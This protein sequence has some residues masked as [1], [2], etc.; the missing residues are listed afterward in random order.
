MFEKQLNKSTTTSDV[1]HPNIKI[2]GSTSIFDTNQ[3]TD[4]NYIRELFKFDT[5]PQH[6]HVEEA[7]FIYTI[8][9]TVGFSTILL[10]NNGKSNYICN[11]NHNSI[12]KTFYIA[13]HISWWGIP[14][15]YF[16]AF[17][18][19]NINVLNVFQ[20]MGNIKHCHQQTL[21]GIKE[22]YIKYNP[23]F[24][25]KE[26]DKICDIVIKDSAKEPLKKYKNLKKHFIDEY[27]KLTSTEVKD[28]CRDLIERFNRIYHPKIPHGHNVWMCT[29]KSNRITIRFADNPKAI[30]RYEGLLDLGYQGFCKLVFPK[31]FKNY[32]D[33]DYQLRNNPYYLK[34]YVV[35]VC[36]FLRGYRVKTI[37]KEKIQTKE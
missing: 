32:E 33:F 35:Y 14:L 10:V 3:Y 28:C 13:S 23:Q 37:D 27:K 34:C 20:N 9:P 31:H 25:I 26:D 7:P 19:S 36:C 11:R 12:Y 8:K 18:S 22:H 6:Y 29:D 5:T 30:Y 24:D 2:N 17:L 1:I 16:Y 15:R 21:N 4:S